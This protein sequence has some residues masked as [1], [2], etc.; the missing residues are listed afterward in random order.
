MNLQPGGIRCIVSVATDTQLTTGSSHTNNSAVDTATV[1][2]LY[3]SLMVHWAIQPA[4]ARASTGIVTAPTGSLSTM[5]PPPLT[6]SALARRTSPWCARTPH[7][8]PIR[9]SKCG[10]ILRT[11]QSDAG[12]AGIFS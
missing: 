4:R 5:T 10:Y 7:D 11:D 12:S 8:G 6:R 3:Y 2:A 1:P 9:R